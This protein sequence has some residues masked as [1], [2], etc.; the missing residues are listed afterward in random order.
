MKSFFS[1]FKD[2]AAELKNIRCLTVTGIL[3]AV[4]ILL[5]MYSIRIGD[6]AKINLAFLALASVGALFGPVPAMLAALAGDLIGCILGGQTPLPL[7][8]LTAIAEGLVY[9]VLLYKKQA[10]KLVVFSI[11]ARLIDSAMISLLLNT[12]V[13]IHYGFMSNTSQQFYIRFIKIVGELVFFIP[14]MIAVIPTVSVIY[15]RVVK[16]GQN[17][18]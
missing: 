12:A 10:A 11:I 1:M 6:F 18:F 5:D 13:L 4:F 8:S 7:L 9:G 16:N 17:N 2:S 3:V 14:A 15:S